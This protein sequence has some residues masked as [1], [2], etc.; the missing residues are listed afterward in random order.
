MQ[1]AIGLV[2]SSICAICKCNAVGTLGIIPKDGKMIYLGCLGGHTSNLV[3]GGIL[4]SD[5]NDVATTTRVLTA[6]NGFDRRRW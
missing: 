6:T 4:E 1:I 5:T 3:D 2:I